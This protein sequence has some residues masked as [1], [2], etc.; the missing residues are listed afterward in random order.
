MN[1]NKLSNLQQRIIFGLSGAALLV[2]G[3]LIS[4]WTYFLIFFGI[5]LVSLIEFYQLLTKSGI[6]SNPGFGVLAGITIFILIFL[7]EKGLVGFQFF[8]LL[9]PFMFILF[10]IEL[11]R[12]QD[13][14]F[15]TIGYTFLGIIYIS[16][17]YGLL[18]V[19]A[20]YLGEYS[21]GIILGILLLLWGND[22]GGYIAG[23][24]I[25]K[26]KL[27]L[28]VSPKKTWE[29]SI[30]GGIM[31]LVAAF[32]IS[33]FIP[34]LAMYQWM[35]LSLIIVV[36]GSY[37]DLVE[38]LFKRSLAIKDSGDLIPG[39]GGFLD[40]FDGLLLAAPFIAAYLKIF[41]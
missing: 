25:G 38:S 8:Y 39:H 12:K 40:R 35:I 41:G 30:G 17:P 37:G 29:G 10:I 33:F 28:R 9:F 16:I 27:F 19:S 14:P 6:K 31:S 20:Y 5:C 18:N 23:M 24:T 26:H 22:V 13:T 3:V 11:F 32:G 1:L 4:E 15:A 34:D 7:M 21:S 36:F 2:S